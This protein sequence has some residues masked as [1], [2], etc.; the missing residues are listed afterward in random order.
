[1]MKNEQGLTLVE[2][3]ASLV[4]LAIIF[5][6]IISILNQSARTNKTSEEIIDATYVAQTEMEHIY[7]LSKDTDK[8]ID[9]IH[10]YVKQ[11]PNGNWN[12][13][14]KQVEHNF[15][16]EI[17]ED[18][19]DEPMVRIVVRVYEIS[20]TNKENPKAQMETLLKWG[21]D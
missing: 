15:F 2:I 19:T 7:K 1:M 11:T 9:S 6:S 18:R 20:D 13:Y 12:V 17:L 16:L 5:I 14:H 10:D 4:I 21:D 3:L 8:T